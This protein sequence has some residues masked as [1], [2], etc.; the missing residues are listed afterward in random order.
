MEFCFLHVAFVILNYVFTFLDNTGAAVV[1][2]NYDPWGA[3][4]AIGGSKADTLGKLNP[5]RYRGYVYDDETGLYYLRSRY[6]KPEW[7][8]F[9]NADT[10]L[11]KVGAVGSQ[12]LFAYC[13]NNPVNRHD[14]AGNKWYDGIVSGWNKFVEGWHNFWDDVDKEIKRQAKV[15]MDLDAAAVMNV[16]AV[17]D[18]YIEKAEAWIK[19]AWR[20]VQDFF[21][22][23]RD[24]NVRAAE[25]RGEL[26]YNASQ[27]ICNWFTENWKKAVDWITTAAGVGGTLYGIVQTF[28]P[29]LPAIPVVG[30]I[31]L[32]GAGLWGAGRLAGLF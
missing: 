25:I 4:L 11:G 32:L 20:D 6:Y 31:V 1:T 7:C 17:V 21:L 9:I 24:A 16:R 14:P 23:I 13:G 28:I 10:V 3:L 18:P 27:N 2:Y 26:M 22:E 5:F 12:N 29:V 15:S 30:Q 8:R 19:Q